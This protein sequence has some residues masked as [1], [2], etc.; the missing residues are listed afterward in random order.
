MELIF[1]CVKERDY[2]MVNIVRQE[3]DKKTKLNNKIVIK[4]KNQLWDEN[5]KLVEKRDFYKELNNQYE[6]IYKREKEKKKNYLKNLIYLI[7]KKI[8]SRY[9][10]SN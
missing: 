9:R 3:I 8:N 6:R 5:K 1:C 10:K 4:S 7:K 2:L